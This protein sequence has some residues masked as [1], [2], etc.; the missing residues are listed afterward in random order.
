[1]LCKRVQGVEGFITS[2]LKLKLTQQEISTDLEADQAK[3][4]AIRFAHLSQ[5]EGDGADQ[6][7]VHEVL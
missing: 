5:V 1:M 4:E 6:M 2:N 3:R 7:R